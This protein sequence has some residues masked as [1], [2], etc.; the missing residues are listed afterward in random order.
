MAGTHPASR[1]IDVLMVSTSYPTD[2]SD[3]HGVFIRHLADA[4]ARR[5]D[6]RLSLWAPPGDVDARIARVATQDEDAWLAKLVAQGG[7]AQLLRTRKTVGLVRAVS[8]L[9]RLRRVYRRHRPDVYHI[10]WLQNALALPH[11]GRPALVT[12]LGADMRIVQWPMVGRLLRRVFRGRP[13]AICPNADW[14][15]APLQAMFGDVARVRAV[16]FGIDDCWYALSRRFEAEPEKMWMVVSRITRDKIGPLFEWCAPLFGAAGRRLHLFGPLIDAI[17]IPDWVEFHG[18]ATPD[19]LCQTWFPKAH[20]LISLS[21]H[22]EGRPQVMLEAM[23]AGLP[24]VASRLPAHEDLLDH[25][26]TGWLVDSPAELADALARLESAATNLATGRAAQARVR[27]EF[28][29]WDDCARRYN[30]LYRQ[31]AGAGA[32]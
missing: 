29:T 14:M 26:N 18:P 23:A 27:A 13:V 15:V 9:R 19:E 28:G 2:R 5:D 32:S 7:I 25:A 6:L 10:N 1:S 21:Q 11:D 8:L 31:L 3:W 12:A 30:D 16:P 20:G 24:I 4:L 22:A 17:A